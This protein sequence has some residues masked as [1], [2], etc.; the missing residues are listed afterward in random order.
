M[1]SKLKK[2]GK[3]GL[4]LFIAYQVVGLVVAIFYFDDII[5]S[6]QEIAYQLIGV[7]K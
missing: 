3:V 1:K 6:S 7:S 5:I 2:L 4:I